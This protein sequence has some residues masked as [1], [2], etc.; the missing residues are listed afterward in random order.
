MLDDTVRL[1]H[2][3]LSSV[4]DKVHVGL[5]FS[6]GYRVYHY[7]FVTDLNQTYPQ[8]IVHETCGNDNMKTMPLGQT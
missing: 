2:P 6:C 5:Q 1:L 3:S 8:P 4:L 7:G